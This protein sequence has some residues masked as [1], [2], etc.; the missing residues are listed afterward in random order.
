M[1]CTSLSN[2]DL[3]ICGWQPVNRAKFIS[4]VEIL[5]ALLC[6]DVDLNVL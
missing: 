3:L 2:P 4:G 6:S 1:R 5:G